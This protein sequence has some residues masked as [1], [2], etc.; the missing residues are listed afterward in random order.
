MYYPYPNPSYPTLRPPCAQVSAGAYGMWRA[1]GAVCRGTAQQWWGGLV[2]PA[3]H[4]QA[5]VSAGPAT[6]A[7]YKCLGALRPTRFSGPALFQLA[8]SPMGACPTY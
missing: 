7:A 5:A 2:S 1:A 4:P 8:T 3:S 6:W